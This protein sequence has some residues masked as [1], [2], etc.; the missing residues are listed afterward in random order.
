MVN[1]NN[2]SSSI[3]GGTYRIVSVLGSGV[4]GNVYRAWHKRL[5][6]HVVIKELIHGSAF[7]GESRRTEVEALKN[8]KSAYLPQ[9]LDF[10]TEHERSFTVMEFIEGESFDILLERGRRFTDSQI[11]RWYGQLASALEELH[12]HDICHR[13]IKPANIMLTPSGN[14]CLID[15][16][17]AMVKGNDSRFVSRSRGYASPEQYKLYKSLKNVRCSAA[18]RGH[19]PENATITKGAE[20]MLSSEI[21]TCVTSGKIPEKALAAQPCNIDWKRSDIYSL[22]ATMYHML[23]C[24]RPKYNSK[25]EIILA[26]AE[27]RHDSKHG[28]GGES[29][30]CFPIVERSMRSSPDERF[31]SAIALSSAIRRVSQKNAKR[32]ITES[33]KA[34]LIISIIVL[35]ALL[36]GQLRKRC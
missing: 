13:D 7:E 31:G 26:R 1:I 4:G 14:V 16:N 8:V 27:K 17:A 25:E 10:V 9:V 20:T 34:F 21:L 24:K 18:T 15:F 35:A 6:K 2:S 29:S 19:P 5:Q 28:N 23:M 36:C 11:T 32:K 22:G 33:I 12:R 3:L 30:P